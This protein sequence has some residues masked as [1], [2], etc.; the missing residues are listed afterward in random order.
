VNMRQSFWRAAAPGQRFCCVI[1]EKASLKVAFG[2]R[3]AMAV[4]YTLSVHCVSNTPAR[5]G[6]SADRAEVISPMW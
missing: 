6:E 5:V 1:Q 2:L 4:C 3:I